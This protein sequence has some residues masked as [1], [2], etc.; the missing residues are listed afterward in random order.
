MIEITKS[1]Q[2]NQTITK[3]E[4]LLRAIRLSTT[5]EILL[6]VVDDLQNPN[7]IDKTFRSIKRFIKKFH[8][9]HNRLFVVSLTEPTEPEQ[10]E[11]IEMNTKPKKK[12]KTNKEKLLA[13]TN[14]SNKKNMFNSEK[15]RKAFTKLVDPIETFNACLDLIVED[16][17]MAKEVLTMYLLKTFF[18]NKSIHKIKLKHSPKDD[19]DSLMTDLSTCIG[20]QDVL[21]NELENGI[22]LAI[23]KNNHLLLNDY[24]RVIKD[25]LYQSDSLTLEDFAH[26]G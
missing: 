16:K 14:E 17:E 15:Y 7:E 24:I 19:T 22:D 4:N 18:R 6:S 1:L 13:I 8:G 25:K 20:F 11:Q 21:Q 9:T 2:K 10:E 23:T 26:A 3:K 12:V 5:D